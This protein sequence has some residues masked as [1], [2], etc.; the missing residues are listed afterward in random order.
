ML[1][2]N[3]GINVRPLCLSFLR[4]KR[5][6]AQFLA[7]IFIKVS[8]KCFSLFYNELEFS[9]THEN[10]WIYY[11]CEE[12]IALWSQCS[13]SL[14]WRQ[15]TR[16]I[17]SDSQ[18]L[19]KNTSTCHRFGV[20]NITPVHRPFEHHRC[21]TFRENNLSQNITKYLNLQR[22]LPVNFHDGT[23]IFDYRF[24]HAFVMA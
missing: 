16:K 9:T 1:Y 15:A 17:L 5:F 22:I 3:T 20:S 8:W 18:T 24:D 11:R 23:A 7:I 12:K 6:S 14:D 19:P 4:K 21:S 13:S 10:I 2:H